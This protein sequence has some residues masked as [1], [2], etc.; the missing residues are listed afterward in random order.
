MFGSNKSNRDGHL[1][2]DALIGAAY[3]SG[4]PDIGA[5]QPDRSSNYV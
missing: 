1:V 2:V 5:P 4:V 3:G